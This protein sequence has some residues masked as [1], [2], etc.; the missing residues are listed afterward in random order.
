MTEPTD[1]HNEEH[2]RASVLASN[3]RVALAAFGIEL[4]PWFEDSAFALYIDNTAAGHA[5]AVWTQSVVLIRDTKWIALSKPIQITFPWTATVEQ[6][7]ETIEA[8]LI[9]RLQ[10]RAAR[11]RRVQGGEHRDMIC[12][13]LGSDHAFTVTGHAF[14]SS[15]RTSATWRCDDCHYSIVVPKPWP[16]RVVPDEEGN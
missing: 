15:D 6:I 2:L 13:N 1:P 5:F 14:V 8:R 12:P 9:A 11:V 10:P 3:L 7:Y 16:H 4:R